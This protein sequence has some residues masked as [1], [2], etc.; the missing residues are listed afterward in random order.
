MEIP[1][2]AR[3]DVID[4]EHLRLLSIGHFVAALNPEMFSAPG[5]SP[6]GSP[7]GMMKIFAVVIGSA[8]QTCSVP[9]GL[10]CRFERDTSRSVLRASVGAP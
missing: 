10:D 3:D 7:D 6:Q 1:Q 4:E 9:M 2:Q 5:Q 8:D